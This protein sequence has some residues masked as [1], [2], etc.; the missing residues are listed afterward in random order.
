MRDPNENTFVS[1]LNITAARISRIKE[2]K[3]EHQIIE[4]INT[5]NGYFATHRDTSNLTIE[6]KDFA[7]WYDPKFITS[8]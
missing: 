8:I 7:F 5:V 3:K 4:P 1:D 2:M 6:M